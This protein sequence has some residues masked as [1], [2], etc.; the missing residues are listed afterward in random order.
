MNSW[1]INNWVEIFLVFNL[2]CWFLILNVNQPRTN[3]NY[4]KG[5][6]DGIKSQ[7]KEIIF[8][9]RHILLDLRENMGAF[10][11]SNTSSGTLK[12][13]LNKL[14]KSFIFYIILMLSNMIRKTDKKS[15][16]YYYKNFNIYVN[17]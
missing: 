5:F 2:F 1:L 4:E 17:N 3:L 6:R 10:I 7:M 12:I 14:D 8:G 9:D 13:A 16:F 15:K 11:V